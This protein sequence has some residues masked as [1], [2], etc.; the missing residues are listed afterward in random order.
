MKTN[1]PATLAWVSKG[2]ATMFVWKESDKDAFP[3]I[4]CEVPANNTT[5]CD[6]CKGGGVWKKQD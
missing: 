6:T 4:G 5:V 1:A 3:C 2:I